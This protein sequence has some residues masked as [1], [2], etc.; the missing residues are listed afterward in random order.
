MGN[1]RDADIPPPRPRA[2]VSAV[3]EDGDAIAVSIRE[4]SLGFFFI[5]L[6]LAVWTAGC[7]HLAWMAIT[8]RQLF[9]VLFGIPIWVSWLFVAIWITNDAFGRQRVSLD[10]NGLM[11]ERWLP[12]MKTRRYVPLAELRGIESRVFY[13]DTEGGV[14]QGIEIQTLGRSIAIGTALPPPE[15]EWLAD[16]LDGHRRRLQIGAGL[17][18][19]PELDP[20]DCR[21]CEPPTDC[22]WLLEDHFGGPQFVQ[23]G[24]L[25][26][27]MIL[28]VPFVTVFWNGVFG[29]F[30]AVLAGLDRAST[31]PLDGVVWWGMFL[32]LIPF[33]V[34]GLAM[35]VG[36][37]T[38]LVEPF[39]VTRWRF[40]HDAVARVTTRG[41][42]PL[43]WNR[44]YCHGGLARAAVSGELTTR[45][46]FFTVTTPTG[47]HYG[48]VVADAAN[49][50]V[51]TIPGLTL[52]EAWWFKGRLQAA[53]LVGRSAATAAAG[54][55]HDCQLP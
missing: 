36:L 43:A 20:P 13:V 9:D 27:A 37:L 11:Y 1:E 22:Q 3:V 46:P 49:V 28:G 26:V 41:G 55:T 2:L 4:G 52:G 45:R 35:F 8:T 23:Q 42:L 16:Q 47:T 6:W 33:E 38:A 40:D 15:R 31:S 32:F 30:V 17:E 10:Q 25:D 14:T 12:L 19:T 44:R 54:S 21:D 50:E 53:G 18:V 29:V 24:R 34:I 7:V 48:L 5:A 51:C 39:R